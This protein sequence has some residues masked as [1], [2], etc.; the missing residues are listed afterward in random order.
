M[1]SKA[2][3]IRNIKVV[4]ALRGDPLSIDLGAS[5]TGT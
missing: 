3:N 2:N 4:K 1:I 5:Y